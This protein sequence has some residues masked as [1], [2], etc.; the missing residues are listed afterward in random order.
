MLYA[1]KPY[2]KKPLLH[3]EKLHATMLMTILKQSMNGLL[4]Y[5]LFNTQVVG[6]VTST[7]EKKAHLKRLN[8]LPYPKSQSQMQKTK[9]E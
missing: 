4:L 2:V 5:L 9:P 3:A 7:L 1:K 8:L 6:K